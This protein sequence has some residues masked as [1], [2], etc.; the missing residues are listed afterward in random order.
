LSPKT[1]TLNNR[2]F[3]F[4][5]SNCEALSFPSVLLTNG[6]GAVIAQLRTLISALCM[7]LYSFTYLRNNSAASACS[8]KDQ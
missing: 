3:F 4:A 7:Q 2:T 5:I 6:S 8:I 1:A